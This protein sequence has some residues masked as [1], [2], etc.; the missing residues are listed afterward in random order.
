MKRF[1]ALLPL[2]LA[3]PVVASAAPDDALLR[4]RGT[5]HDALFD[6]AF[7][8]SFGIAVG[9][10]GTV[11]TSEDSGLTWTQDTRPETP[12]ALL[13]VAVDGHRRFAVG[14][15][16]RIYRFEGS[17]WRLL[18]SGTE[19]RLLQVGLGAGGLVVVVGGFGTILV[20][21]DD[22]A[23][24]AMPR[25][26]WTALLN[27][28]LEPHLYAVHVAGNSVLIAGEF[29]LVLRSDDRGATWS[30][31]HRG[32]ESIFDMAFN[33]RGEG[34]AVGQNGLALATQ[35]GGRTWRR[36]QTLSE[37]NLLGVWMSDR[38]VFAA[39]IR[40]AYASQDGGRNW[41]PV[42]R[43]DIE[44]GWYQAVSASAARGKPMLVGHRGRIL[45]MDE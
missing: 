1:L 23:T 26:D 33:G 8:G 24:W 15:S 22:G 34:V 21:S 29:G 40:G 16:G 39:G 42:K 17:S 11:L 45:E 7:D 18:E 32:E 5:A 38:R 2:F 37:T 35:D 30:V 4:H 44:T 36:L 6:I 3:L 28:F 41:T 20:S 14:Q 31:T 19:E 9:G 27:D 13:G 43:S 12:L 25:V 10:G